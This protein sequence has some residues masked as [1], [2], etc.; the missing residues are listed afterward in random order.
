M[1]IATPKV[2]L[3]KHRDSSRLALETNGWM[4]LNR[5]LGLIERLP[6]QSEDHT[7]AGAAIERLRMQARV[8]G[9]PAMLRQLLARD[10][11]A[12][13]AERPPSLLY[14]AIVWTVRHLSAS[15]PAGPESVRESVSEL[16][17]SLSSFKAWTRSAN[18]ELSEAVKAD[19]AN[20]QALQE[21]VGGLQHR[22]ASLHTQI[23][24]LPFLA[25]RQK[26][27]Q[28]ENDR[29]AAET[30]L[31]RKAAEAETR[32]QV[33]AQLEAITTE[34]AWLEAGLEDTT[35]FLTSA[36]AAFGSTRDLALNAA[37]SRFV[38]SSIVDA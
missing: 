32:R 23:A 12:L 21:A 17:D 27:E 2:S 31:A 3:L 20:L 9:T 34:G 33:L 19:G 28:L 35:E 10:P 5:Y 24:K 25:T 4:H 16:L 1:N 11:D 7:T 30:E 6:A 26:R 38:T 15:H 18:R 37:A 14:G 29:Q 22:I 8:F 13:A 36:R